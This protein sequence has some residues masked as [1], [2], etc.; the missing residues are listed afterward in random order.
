MNI[1]DFY[2]IDKGKLYIGVDAMLDNKLYG[3]DISMTGLDCKPDCQI[4]DFSNNFY[5]RTS[6]GIHSQKYNSIM[7]FKN[8]VSRLLKNKGFNIKQFYYRLDVWEPKIAF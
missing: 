3:M 1:N 2:T 6:K 8:G 7:S 5:F 4:G